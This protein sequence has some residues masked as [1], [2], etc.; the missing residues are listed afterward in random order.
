MFEA[1]ELV[2]FRHARYGLNFGLR[3]EYPIIAPFSSSGVTPTIS[4]GLI[5]RPKQ[6]TLGW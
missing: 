2:F 5:Q 4:L 1:W 6:P 3:I